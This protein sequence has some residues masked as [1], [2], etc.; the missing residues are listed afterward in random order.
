MFYSLQQEAIIR[1]RYTAPMMRRRAPLFGVR[2]FPSFWRVKKMPY[3]SRGDCAALL[4]VFK[5]AFY[6][7][8]VWGNLILVRAKRNLKN[9]YSI[10]EMFEG[11]AAMR[12]RFLP[13]AIL[14]G[15]ESVL[16]NRGRADIGEKAEVSAQRAKLRILRAMAKCAWKGA[17][18]MHDKMRSYQNRICWIF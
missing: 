4:G 15:R 6:R 2:L 3:F 1:C 13:C 12:C 10:P 5:R 17:K 8:H 11:R 7:W 16:P 18:N 14:F 9:F